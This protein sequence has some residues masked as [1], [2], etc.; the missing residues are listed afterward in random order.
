VIPPSLAKSPRARELIDGRSGQR[1]SFAPI[2]SWSAQ[3]REAAPRLSHP[4]L[5]VA[6]RDE[7][8]GRYRNAEKADLSDRPTIDDHDLAKG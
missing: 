8:A 7:T 5:G 6:R 4:S 3:S 1:S 2:C